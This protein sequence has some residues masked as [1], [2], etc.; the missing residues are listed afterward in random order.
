MF[1]SRSLSLVLFLLFISL[2][3]SIVGQE[4]A[5]KAERVDDYAKQR[6][7]AA[8]DR[9]SIPEL[10]KALQERNADVRRQAALVLA[11]RGPEAT[12]SI[13]ALIG[14]L[15]DKEVTVR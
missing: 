3:H 7:A 5:G 8:N 12:D 11:M 4:G 15:K 6:E 14:A 13:P 9:R 1:S 2:A 10:I